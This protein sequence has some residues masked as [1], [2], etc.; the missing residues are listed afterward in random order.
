MLKINM[1]IRHGILFIRL[2]G[3]LNKLTSN[4]INNYIIPMLK[5]YDIRFLSYNLKDLSSIDKTGINSLNNCFNIINSN[6]GISYICGVNENI[7][8]Q[9]KEFKALEV[10]NELNVMECLQI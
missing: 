3:N 4:K 10:K 1:E 2:N 6:N 7:S 8:K 5:K 9:I